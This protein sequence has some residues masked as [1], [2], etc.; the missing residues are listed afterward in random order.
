MIKTLFA[1]LR[2]LFYRVFKT[3]AIRRIVENSSYLLSATGLT[4]VVSVIQGI[5][6]FRMIGAEGIGL[7]GAIRQFANNANR[8]TSFRINEMVVSYVRRY[9]EEGEQEKAAAV[10]KLAGLFE[11]AGAVAAFGLIWILAPW[12]ASFFGQDSS[13]LPLWIM[14]GMVVLVNLLYESSTGLLHVF[15]RFRGIAVISAVQSVVTL[16]F[17]VIAYFSNG[18][19]YEVL[20]AYILG[21]LVG[22]V[23][24]TSTA[25][26]TARR[27]WGSGWWRVPLGG[28]RQDRGKLLSFA[29]STNF[30]HT[31]TLVAKESE[32]LWVAAF[33]GL[34]QA[35]Y[36]K[37]ALDIISS[38]K[39]PIIHLAKTTYPELSKE[40]ANKRWL[41]VKDILNRGSRLAVAY[42]IPVLFG[43]VFFGKMAME[44]LYTSDSLPAFPL[45][46]V[47]A[48]GHSFDN[49]FF[50]NR[51]ALLA[52]G[53]PIFPTAV[54]FIGMLLK[55]G[56]I[57]YLV[58]RFG[59]TAFA[60]ILAGYFIFTV[61]VSASRVILDVY[62]RLS[63][64]SSLEASV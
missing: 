28:L 58:P 4:M 44:I 21:K 59:A 48:I 39:L 45:V 18:G 42:S 40:I 30:S 9:E 61:G 37:L 24:V 32:T 52:L 64:V 8:L 60:V 22:A 15:N 53:R 12:G 29:V 1:S 27:T 17:V 41:S 16:C 10:F 63:P 62:R 35:G 20:T 14:Y 11:V 49:T 6:V 34:T 38:L 2:K 33:L 56:M 31:I 26:F 19:I 23:G 47:L 25:F 3:E 13:T 51:V 5:F 46:I 50:W 55:V 54:N 7:L 57:F 36:Y 43:L